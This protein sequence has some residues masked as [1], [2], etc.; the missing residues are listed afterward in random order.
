MSETIDKLVSSGTFTRNQVR[1][2]TGEE[3]ANDPELD[4]FIITKNLQSMTH[5]K[6]VNRMAN[7]I[8][9][10]VPQFKKRN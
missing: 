9:N 2:V 3:P 7:K 10:V 1:I 5:L 8:P 4:K 6:E